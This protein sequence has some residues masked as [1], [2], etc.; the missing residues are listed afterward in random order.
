[1][2]G[3]SGGPSRMTGEALD[4]ADLGDHGVQMGGAWPRKLKD[5]KTSRFS[6]VDHL[7]DQTIRPT[8]TMEL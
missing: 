4:S 1:M 5:S 6:C 8:Q 2:T 3:S 7:F